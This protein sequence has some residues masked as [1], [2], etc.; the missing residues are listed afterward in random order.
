MPDLQP[1]HLPPAP[2]DA[3]HAQVVRRSADDHIDVGQG[4]ADE[5]IDQGPSADEQSNEES[6]YARIYEDHRKKR[7]FIPW[8][9]ARLQGTLPLALSARIPLEVFRLT[10]DEMDPPTLTVAALVCTAWYPRAMHN[11]YYTIVIRSRTSYNLLFKQC[12]ASPRVKQWLASTCELTVDEQWDP[13]RDVH[14]NNLKAQEKGEDKDGSVESPQRR[15]KSR[16]DKSFLQALPSALAGLMPR[17]RILR[18][19]N[20]RLRFFRT[21]FFSALSRFESVKSLTLSMCRLNNVTQLRRIVSAFPQLTNLTMEFIFFAQRGAASYAGASLFGAPPH[22][23]LRHLDV[24]VDDEHMV[25][26]LDWMARSDLCTSLANLTIVSPYDF[27]TT[28]SSLNQLLKTAGAS[29]SRFCEGLYDE[30]D[31]THGNLLQ[32]TALQSLDFALHGTR[33][34]PEDEGLRAAWT[35]AAGRLH[36]ILSTVRSRQLEHI[37]FAVD[38]DA[39]DSILESEEPSA[40]LEKLNLRGLH[41]V[42]S[43]PFFDT[44]KD[45][46]AEI[47]LY[48]GSHQTKSDVDGIIQKLQAMFHSILQPWSD[49]GIVTATW[50]RI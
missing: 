14:M 41:E 39:G 27:P 40:V 10:I 44:L 6:S 23:R 22:M 15:N 17:L 13:Y 12:H 35:R 21:D 8:W 29:L 32:N 31:L 42:M 26:F 36:G 1:T 33:Y 38:V 5:Q 24:R 46:N 43:Q 28:Q 25:V 30:D 7:E 3:S 19:C 49:R 16:S 9:N 34:M 45:V 18:I 11:L 37:K 47:H 20:A 50:R 4:L 48:P 2:E